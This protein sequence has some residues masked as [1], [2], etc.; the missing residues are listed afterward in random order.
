MSANCMRTITC[1]TVVALMGSMFDMCGD[2]ET[3]YWTDSY[4][5]ESELNLIQN[6]G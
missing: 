2:Y 5:Q 4:L 3:S 6:W 1:S